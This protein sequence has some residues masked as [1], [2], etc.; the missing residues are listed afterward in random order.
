M[1]QVI[2]AMTTTDSEGNE[3]T[4]KKPLMQTFIMFLAMTL[5]LPLFYGFLVKTHTRT[6]KHTRM[7]WVR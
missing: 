7:C 3:V 6:A 5:A 2:L 4:Y 1:G